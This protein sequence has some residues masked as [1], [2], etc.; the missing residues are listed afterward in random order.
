MGTFATAAGGRER[1]QKGVAAVE[2]IKESE[3]SPI[4]FGHRNRA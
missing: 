4:F 1:E 3:S 2:K